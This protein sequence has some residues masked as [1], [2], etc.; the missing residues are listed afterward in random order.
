[1]KMKHVIRKKISQPY[2]E[3]NYYKIK[4]ELSAQIRAWHFFLLCGQ[5]RNSDC[6]DILSL[7]FNV[8]LDEI[9]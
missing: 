4:E 6:S 7:V 5:N 8:M 3:T 2:T 9:L 1:M